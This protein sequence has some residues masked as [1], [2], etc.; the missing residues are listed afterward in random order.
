MR[1]P[2]ELPRQLRWCVRWR[3]LLITIVSAAVAAFDVAGSW[4][5][6]TDWVM[7]REGGHLLFSHAGLH[8]YAH[9]PGLQAGPPTLVVCHLLELAF[10]AH[11]GLV[12]RLFLMAELPVLVWLA[13]RIAR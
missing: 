7:L 12:G 3:Y 9:V 11:A 8:T 10:G 5:E 13:E 1:G 6:G 4:S 2:A